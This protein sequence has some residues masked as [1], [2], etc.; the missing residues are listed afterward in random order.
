MVII[1]TIQFDWP[2][3][4]INTWFCFI[5]DSLGIGISYSLMI[6]SFSFFQSSLGFFKLLFWIWVFYF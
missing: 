1:L 3:E 4:A 6:H 5:F 2:K